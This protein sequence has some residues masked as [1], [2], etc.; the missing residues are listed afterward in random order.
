MFSS[1]SEPSRAQL[2]YDRSMR[3][4]PVCI[5]VFG[6][7]ALISHL[8]I[9]SAQAPTAFAD[10]YLGALLE[11]TQRARL[12]LPA[13]T[14]AGDEVSRRL[15]AGGN[16]YLASVRP[17]FVSEGTGRAG[18]LAMAKAYRPTTE[19]S[20]KDVVI[21]SWLNPVSD[22]DL[23]LARRL[24]SSGAYVVGIG[25]KP[26][27]RNARQLRAN[28]GTFLESSL[29]LSAAVTQ[30][31]KDETYA[32]IS[33]QNLALLWAFTGEIVSSLTRQGH[34]PAILASIQVAR[35]TERNQGLRDMR[36][37]D[38]HPV[39]AVPV[40]E[41]AQT[42]LNKIAEYYR[43]LRQ[44]E[45]GNI[46]KVAQACLQVRK[47]GHEIHVFLTPHFPLYQPG[48]PGDPGYMQ[49]F[50]HMSGLA[51]PQEQ[52]KS[53]LKPGDLFFFLG[54]YRRQVA[55]YEAARQVGAQI[56]E[57]ISGTGTPETAPPFPDYVIHPQW[58]YGDAVVVIPGYD[59]KMFPSSGL[60]QSA[61]Y[62]AVVGSMAADEKAGTA[63]PN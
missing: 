26:P 6:A 48:A 61:I 28:L 44:N 40:G 50:E 18:G 53:V 2:T 14:R 59:V 7:L 10:S 20:R 51:P 29:P 11:G 54:Y 15:V 52:L 58:P 4:F 47:N 12:D 39:P 19:L 63:S 24:H 27:G 42:Y 62:W 23:E 1:I 49:P 37:D 17:D 21:F 31:F 55:A 38:E 30:D 8:S 16:F 60:I 36:F 32:L 45:R 33:L 56:V 25:P 57:V 41:L 13:M 9:L 35:G 3:R 34:M 43:G 22:R 46:E 5:T